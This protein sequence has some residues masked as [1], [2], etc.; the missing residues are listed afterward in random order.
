MNSKICQFDQPLEI[1]YQDQYLV[2][3]NKPADLLVHRSPIDRHEHQFALQMVR[4][5]IGQ[6][7]WPLHRLDKPTSG[8]L[9]FGLSAEVASMMGQRFRENATEHQLEKKYLAIVRGWVQQQ[10]LDAADSK[11]WIEIDHPFADKADSIADK[12][13]S[14]PAEVKPALSFYRSLAQGTL[15]AEI[16]RYPQSRFSLLEIAPKT[17]RKHQIRRHLKHIA[18]PII[19]DA[20]YGKG[21]YN[22]WFAENLAVDRLLLHCQMM[23]FDHPIT[24]ERLEITAGL[25]ERFT[26]ALAGLN[27]KIP[28]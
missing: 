1:L 6:Y 21:N 13:K 23:A 27:I 24:G 10:K 5:Q 22:R 14:Q 16:D 17:G 28:N 19:G 26:K 15:E 18:Q 4:D 7:V 3:I 8:V 9:V 25:D 11:G 12:D 20:N 2:A